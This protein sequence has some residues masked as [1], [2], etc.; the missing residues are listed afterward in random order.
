[1]VGLKLLSDLSDDNRPVLGEHYANGSDILECVELDDCSQCYLNDIQQKTG[2]S[3]AQCEKS[4]CGTRTK[5]T[6]YNNILGFFRK[7]SAYRED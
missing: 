1:M 6:N 7:C 2:L 3:H 5:E 4:G